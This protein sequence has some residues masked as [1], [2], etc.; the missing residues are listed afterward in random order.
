VR[1]RVCIR[2]HGAKF[3][4]GEVLRDPNGLGAKR[5]AFCSNALLPEKDRAWGIDLD[6]QRNDRKQRQKC[7]EHQ[8]GK[9]YIQ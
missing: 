1:G 4:H 9:D 7:N 6:Q 8:D 3:V 5:P 2:N